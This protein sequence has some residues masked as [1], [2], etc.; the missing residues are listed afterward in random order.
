VRGIVAF[1]RMHHITTVLWRTHSVC[2]NLRSIRT[3]TYCHLLPL[4]LNLAVVI[5]FVIVCFGPHAGVIM[6]S[7]DSVRQYC[8]TSEMFAVLNWRLSSG[9][10]S[11]IQLFDP[12]HAAAVFQNACW[13]LLGLVHSTSIAVLLEICRCVHM[14]ELVVCAH[15]FLCLCS[16]V[17]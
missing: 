7:V 4:Y 10:V 15:C 6:C 11:M 8:C 14:S 17:F 12:E 1:E 3:P 5:L 13:Y 16:M 2:D 9:S